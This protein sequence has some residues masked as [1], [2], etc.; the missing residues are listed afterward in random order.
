MT[1]EPFAPFAPAVREPADA[2]SPYRRGLIGLPIQ[3]SLFARIEHSPRVIG[4][5]RPLAARLD[6]DGNLYL[7]RASA[8]A[9][10]TEFRSTLAP[11]TATRLEAEQRAACAALMEEITSMAGATGLDAASC[12][13][14]IG[15]L[16]TRVETVVHFGIMAKFAP[17]AVLQELRHIGDDRPPPTPV[18]SPG[19]ALLDAL[20]ELSLRCHRRGVPPERLAEVWPA[21]PAVVRDDVAAFCAA[22]SGFGPLPWD[23][24]GYED[25]SYTVRAMAGAFGGL[26]PD[27]VER[28]LGVPPAVRVP[29]HDGPSPELRG[30]LAFWLEFLERETWFV[31]RAF[32]VGML[33]LLRRLAQ[34]DGIA[35]ADTLLFLRIEELVGQPPRPDVVEAR[36]AAYLADHAY[37]ARHGIG[38]ERLAWLGA[39]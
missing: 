17:D 9:V 21:V 1:V 35:R 19:R 27:G 5:D 16:A 37:L 26:T 29:S 3:R 12:R 22:Q 13:A 14:S 4:L 7:D 20:A 15:R 18:P 11:S 28:R 24:P 31:R 25:P 39:A 2:T 32:L 6:D 30:Y 36:S 38:P 10:A 8:R 33:P 34:L 23:A